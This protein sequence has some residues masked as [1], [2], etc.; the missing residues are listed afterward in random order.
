MRQVLVD[1]LVG[2]W[3]DILCHHQESPDPPVDPVDTR[4]FDDVAT[5]ASCATSGEE[6]DVHGTTSTKAAGLP[7]D[8]I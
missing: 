6:I 1:I 2:D 8:Q 7:F 3:R 5:N 4:S